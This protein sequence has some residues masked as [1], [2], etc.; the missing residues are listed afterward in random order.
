MEHLYY[1]DLQLYYLYN[2]PYK[3]SNSET[4]KLIHVIHCPFPYPERQTHI[5][6]MYAT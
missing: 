6:S 1:N 2:A 5:L 3:P 4:E